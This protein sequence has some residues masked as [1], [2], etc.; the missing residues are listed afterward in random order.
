MHKAR[1]FLVCKESVYS[2][3]KLVKTS[4]DEEQ[5][6]KLDLWWERE[7]RLIEQEEEDEMRA[8]ENS[9]AQ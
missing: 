8:I 5:T 6:S 7:T 2:K 9:F 1:E 3:E 4:E